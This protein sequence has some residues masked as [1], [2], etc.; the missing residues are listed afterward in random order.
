MVDSLIRLTNQGEQKMSEDVKVQEQSDLTLLKV[1]GSRG[2]EEDREYVK[3]LANALLQTFMK[4]ESAKLRCVGAGS[5]NNAD[6]A[7]IIATGEAAKKGIELVEKKSFTSVDFG[8]G[9]IKTGILK[10]IVKR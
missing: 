1:N 3:K 9:V 10:E 6:K 2:K 4:H 7:V 5:V 8:G